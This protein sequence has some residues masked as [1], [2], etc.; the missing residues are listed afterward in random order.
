MP[1]CHLSYLAFLSRR[2]CHCLANGHFEPLGESGAGEEGGERSV[3]SA[4]RL[5]SDGS[6]SNESQTGFHKVNVVLRFAICLLLGLGRA[7]KTVRLM[8][9]LLSTIQRQSP[10]SIKQSPGLVFS[11]FWVNLVLETISGHH[12]RSCTLLKESHTSPGRIM[13]HALTDARSCKARSSISYKLSLFINLF[14]THYLVH[15]VR[16][17]GGKNGRVFSSCFHPMDGKTGSG[18]RGA[19]PRSPGSRVGTS[20][21]EFQCL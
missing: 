14:H 5:R 13:A 3:F 16:L 12:G 1:T 6:A 8:G 21:V 15:P 4:T 17:G 19:F 9:R 7:G 10:A 11:I 18:R 2:V 20:M